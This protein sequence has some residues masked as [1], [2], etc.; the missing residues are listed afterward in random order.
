[1]KEKSP[2]T[3][4]AMEAEI[5]RRIKEIERAD[6]QFPQR[7]KKADWIGFALLMVFCFIV[8]CALIGYCAVY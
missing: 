8:I 3:S 1:M 6:Y 5:E 7:L 2:Y 4:K